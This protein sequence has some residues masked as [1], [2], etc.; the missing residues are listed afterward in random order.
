VS[1]QVFELTLP[2]EW[3]QVVV[4]EAPLALGPWRTFVF[5]RDLRFHPA[6]E[7]W[8]PGPRVDTRAL[9]EENVETLMLLNLDWLFP[10]YRPALCGKSLRDWAGADIE[11]TDPSGCRHV[12]E[13]KFGA[14]ANNV[15]DQALSYALDVVPQ[16]SALLP[17]FHEL[18][19]AE[20]HRF[21]TCR[22]AGFW[23]QTRADKWERSKT[24]PP[25]ERDWHALRAQLAARPDLGLDE[26]QCRA[27]AAGLETSWPPP[28]PLPRR[29][30]AV[31]FHLAVPDPAKIHRDQLYALARLRW[32]GHR[33]SIWQVAAEVNGMTGRFSI[34]EC[35]VPATDTSRSTWHVPDKPGPHRFRIGEVLAVMAAKDPELFATL[36]TPAHARG[37]S[38]TVG[39]SWHGEFPGATL[40]VRTTEQ[41]P[42]LHVEAWVINP[43]SL[44]AQ[45]GAGADTI[46]RMRHE[47]MA[48]WILGVATPPD[49]GLAQKVESLQRSPH[50]WTSRDRL[51][52]LELRA[53]HSGGLKT[54]SLDIPLDDLD[55]ASGIAA[56]AMRSLVAEGAARRGAFGVDAVSL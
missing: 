33:A 37:E 56:R 10:G 17:H 46:R 25:A 51:T 42:Q 52:G 50:S 24:L 19:A 16:A 26:P 36:P 15:I 6:S 53:W 45:H 4:N 21:L 1:Q 27:L 41:A 9:R 32:R 38:V 18:P 29:L 54:A 30:S 44:D 14:A 2:A 48:A 7:V 47:A 34:R 3:S 8:D 13:V 43:E 49:R 55:A 39:H 28:P 12:V 20:R 35:W 23:T 40:S 31:H 11:F 22:T 5:G